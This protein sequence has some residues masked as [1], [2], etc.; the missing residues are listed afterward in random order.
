MNIL[1]SLFYI[2]SLVNHIRSS[3][4][5]VLY[6]PVP[7]WRSDFQPW[8][9]RAKCVRPV[10]SPAGRCWCRSVLVFFFFFT[11]L[12]NSPLLHKSIQQILTAHRKHKGLFRRGVKKK[13]KKRVSFSRRMLLPVGYLHSTGIL[14]TEKRVSHFLLT[15]RQFW[16]P[17]V[18]P[19]S[20]RDTCYVLR[21]IKKELI[22]IKAWKNQN[23][24]GMSAARV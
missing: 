22:A 11:G 20:P 15:E 5:T 14:T 7:W 1:V 18:L 13:K 24:R 12:I 4:N 16:E 3:P 10:L 23:E 19:D 17:R 2:T 21:F 9:R 6:L 8:H